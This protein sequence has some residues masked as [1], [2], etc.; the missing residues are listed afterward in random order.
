MNFFGTQDYQYLTSRGTYK[1]R[2]GSISGLFAN[3]AT[4]GGIKMSFLCCPFWRLP[5]PV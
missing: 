1:V 5:W 3:E 2:K 4:L